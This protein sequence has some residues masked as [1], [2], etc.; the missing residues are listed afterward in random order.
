MNGGGSKFFEPTESIRGDDDPSQV[1]AEKINCEYT[2]SRLLILVF[3]L[4][5]IIA[6]IVCTG[7]EDLW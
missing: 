5:A 4:V 2:S 7:K 1:M 6:I 3:T